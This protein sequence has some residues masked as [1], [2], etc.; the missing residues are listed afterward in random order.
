MNRQARIN[1]RHQR[2]PFGALALAVL[3]GGCGSNEPL[4]TGLDELD[5]APRHIAEEAAD[6]ALQRIQLAE[7]HA[8]ISRTKAF[9]PDAKLF[10]LV[11]R[12]A[13]PDPQRPPKADEL[14]DPGSA[15]DPKQTGEPEGEELAQVV[16]ADGR[17]YHQ[18]PGVRPLRKSIYTDIVLSQPRGIAPVKPTDDQGEGALDRELRAI[19]PL[20]EQPLVR[21]PSIG[22]LRQRQIIGSDNRRR[23]T[24]LTHRGVGVRLQP[25]GASSTVWCSGSMISPRVVL[26]A[27]HCITDGD[28]NFDRTLTVSPSARGSSYGGARWPQGIRNVSLYVW[29]R[30]W[31]GSG[32]RY[33]YALL[34]LADLPPDAS[35]SVQWNPRPVLFGYRSNLFWYL[36]KI[37]NNRGYPANGRTCAD[38]AAGDGGS[39]NGYMYYNPARGL[40]ALSSALIHKF[41]TQGGRAVRP[42]ISTVAACARSTVC[43]RV[44]TAR[45][46]TAPIASGRG[47]SA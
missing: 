34:V 13:L 46:T 1:T 21:S 5:E 17:L 9:E 19:K 42:S 4:S 29:P 44:L 20:L 14:P 43:T 12:V 35:G 18:R 32:A 26:T 40:Y 28:G 6:P 24:S 7:Y 22:T 15:E 11:D 33:D 8:F 23:S 47:A 16:T 3:V 36:G 27:A 2:Y 38:A 41:D 45:A 37:F 30:G 39:C 25:V 10:E 31:H